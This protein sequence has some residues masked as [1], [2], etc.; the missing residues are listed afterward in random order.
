MLLRCILDLVTTSAGKKKYFQLK[1]IC[2]ICGVPIN[3]VKCLL[4]FYILGVYKHI[5][6]NTRTLRKP[7]YLYTKVFWNSRVHTHKILLLI[8]LKN[9]YCFSKKK[10]HS[11]EKL[12]TLLYIRTT[13]LFNFYTQHQSVVGT[14]IIIKILLLLFI[15]YFF[16]NKFTIHNFIQVFF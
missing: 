12:P 5:L 7:I 3:F 13:F 9:V 6:S 2:L 14:Y 8:D 1:Q 11:T 10:Q 15:F 4:T 16:F